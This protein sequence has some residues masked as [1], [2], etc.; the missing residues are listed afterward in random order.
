MEQNH[1]L[2]GMVAE[3]LEKINRIE[4]LLRNANL[5]EPDSSKT[6]NSLFKCAAVEFPIN[7]DEEFDIFEKYLEN[8]KEFECGVSLFFYDHQYNYVLTTIHLINKLCCGLFKFLIFECSVRDFI[9]SVPLTLNYCD[10]FK[11]FKHLKLVKL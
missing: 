5:N 4:V 7:T 3:S 6:T 8:E 10:T 11:K 9:F 2:R 1:I